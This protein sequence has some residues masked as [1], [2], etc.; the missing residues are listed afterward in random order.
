M[1][2]RGCP[3]RAFCFTAPCADG[4]KESGRTLECTEGST[5][6]NWPDTVFCLSVLLV[7]LLRLIWFVCA[8]LLFWMDPQGCIWR[9]LL[10][11]AER[12]K[13]KWEVRLSSQTS[14]CSGLHERRAQFKSTVRTVCVLLFKDPRGKKN[15][16]EWGM[17]FC[18]ALTGFAEIE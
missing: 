11:F 12:R 9:L 3:Y 8:A 4:A 5:W 16:F 1:D 2:S 13:S 14:P 6:E 17:L 18:G 15:I 7:S 10:L